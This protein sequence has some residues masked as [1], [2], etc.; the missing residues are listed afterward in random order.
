MVGQTVGMQRRV[1]AG[2]TLG[3][4][5]VAAIGAAMASTYGVWDLGGAERIQ[6]LAGERLGSWIWG[7]VLLGVGVVLVAAG[8]AALAGMVDDAVT[9]VGGA[10]AVIAG[11]LAAIAFLFQGVGGAAAA[12]LLVETGE[13]PSGFYV[14]DAIQDRML[15][16][17]GGLMSLAS[18]TVGFRLWNVDWLPR[19]VGLTAVGVS[20]IS[21]A[22]LPMNIPFLAL[23]G[24]VVLGV[25]LLRPGG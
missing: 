17:F 24:A 8:M 11:T 21:L 3:G 7:N 1:L 12:E 25:G 23:L 14:I 18:V 20:I 16:L 10:L 4:A 19:D 9:R 13:T 6:Q 5:A 2:A 22:L 15:V